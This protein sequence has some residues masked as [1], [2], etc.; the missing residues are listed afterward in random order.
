MLKR[1]KSVKDLQ[2]KK[3]E[4]DNSILEKELQKAYKEIIELKWVIMD[5]CDRK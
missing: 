3:L 4:D 5:W 1:N 2:I